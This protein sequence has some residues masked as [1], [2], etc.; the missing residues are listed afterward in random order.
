MASLLDEPTPV[1]SKQLLPSSG[2]QLQMAGTPTLNPDAPEFRLPP[3]PPKPTAS[4]N[5]SIE[6]PEFVPLAAKSMA[7]SALNVAAPEFVPPALA[8]TNSVVMSAGGASLTT[9]TADAVPIGM[10]R[11]QLQRMSHELEASNLRA[12]NAE[13]RAGA[14]RPAGVARTAPT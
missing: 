5:L 7:S 8:K 14:A 6:A 9:Y 11:V 12:A 4:T 2:L 3:S 10:L 1:K 13:A